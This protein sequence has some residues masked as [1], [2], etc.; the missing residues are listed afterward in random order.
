[1]KKAQCSDNNPSTC[2]NGCVLLGT[3]DNETYQKETLNFK[4]C[5]GEFCL[6]ELLLCNSKTSSGSVYQ[7]VPSGLEAERNLCVRLSLRKQAQD[8]DWLEHV[9]SMEERR[10]PKLACSKST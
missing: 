2:S 9:E 1:M 10:I 6:L 4:Y 5:S 8:E 7:V 3:E